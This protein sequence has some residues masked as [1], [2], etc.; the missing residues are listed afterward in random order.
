[1]TFTTGD[2]ALLFNVSAQTIINW[3]DAKRIKYAKLGKSRKF[4]AKNILVYIEEN[5]IDTDYLNPTIFKQ[6]NLQAIEDREVESK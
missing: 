4:L 3:C 5:S 1:M 2:L 6:I